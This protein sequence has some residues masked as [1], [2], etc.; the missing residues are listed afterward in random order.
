MYFTAW[1]FSKPHVLHWPVARAGLELV[2]R[3]NR[4]IAGHLGSRHGARY[5]AY[6]RIKS[7]VDRNEG[8]LFDS[9]FDVPV[10]RKALTMIHQYPL[11][12]GAADQINRQI[13]SGVCDED[14]A[15]LVIQLY[16]LGKLC[17]VQEKRD[18]A[19]AAIICSLG[20]AAGEP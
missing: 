17:I 14:F 15:R 3:S 2:T 8:G 19:C 18:E 11:T 1:P 9:L 7:F 6:E 4:T 5:K 13:R 16:D 12:A 20:L 10:L